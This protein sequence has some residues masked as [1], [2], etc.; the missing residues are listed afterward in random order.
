MSDVVLQ[1]LVVRMATDA[2]FADLVRSAPGEALGAF[3]L[4]P[5]EVAQLSSLGADVGASAEGLA[6]R[7][8][9]S[10]LLFMGMHHPADHGA[11]GHA[12][13]HQPAI[14]NVNLHDPGNPLHGAQVHGSVGPQ[15]HM[16]GDGAIMITDT[17]EG[18]PKHDLFQGG[19]HSNSMDG[20]GAIMITDTHE[21]G[22]KHDLFQG[23]GHSNSMDGD[24]GIMITDTHEGGPKQDLFT[25]GVHPGGENVQVHGSGPVE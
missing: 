14:A 22:P 11:V 19:G 23:G 17:H 15:S 21:G 6:A 16:D 25:G 8:S 2:G 10:S 4:T 13:L 20:D 12:G 1:E 7:Q 9:K 5:D 18:G 24:G 3:D